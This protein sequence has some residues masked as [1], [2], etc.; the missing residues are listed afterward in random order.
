MM[1]WGRGL[2]VIKVRNYCILQKKKKKIINRL[3]AHQ[4]QDCPKCCLSCWFCYSFFNQL[5]QGTM[6]TTEEPVS[7]E[8]QQIASHLKSS[9]NGISE[10]AQK[11][12]DGDGTKVHLGFL[13]NKHLEDLLLWRDVKKSG[14]VLGG[15]TVVYYLLALSGMS[16]ISIIAY[17]L[18]GVISGAYL[19]ANAGNLVKSKFKPESLLP[20]AFKDGLTAKDIQ[21]FAEKYLDQI[22]MVLSNLYRVLSGTDAALSIKVVGALFVVTQVFRWFSPLTL[23]YLVIVIAF[24]VPKFYELNKDQCDKYL[25]IAHDKVAELYKKFDEQVLKK[26]PKAGSKKVD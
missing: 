13:K 25:K 18:L 15:A 26:I 4:Y 24:T 11:V 7:E 19:W 2:L 21:E 9:M 1:W 16:L 23:A 8:V 10:Q 22:N 12:L 6:A 3:Y 14:A 5:T 20:V 17:L